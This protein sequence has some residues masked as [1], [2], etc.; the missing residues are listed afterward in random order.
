MVD[1]PENEARRLEALRR[2][3]ILDTPPEIA[4]D[5]ITELAAQICGCPIAL[6]GLIDERRDWLKAKY[7]PPNLPDESPRDSV[8]CATVINRSDLLHVPDLSQDPRFRDFP[9]VKGPPHQKFYCGM[10]LIT[11]DGYAVGTLCVTDIKPHELSV[12][13]QEAMRRLSRQVMTQLE[14][15][16][17]IVERNAMLGELDRMRQDA[18]E[19]RAKSDQLLRNVLPDPIARELQQTQRVQPRYYDSVSILFLD[20]VDFTSHAEELE[21]AVL[22]NQLDQLFTRFDEIAAQHRLEKLKTIGDAHMSAGGLPEPNRT[23]ALDAVL[24]GFAMLDFVER[25][26]RQREKLRM[27]P[28]QV[29]IGIHTGPVIAGVVGT[30][31][32]AYDVWGD[33]VNVAA[34]MEAAGAPGRINVSESTRHRIADVCATEPR[35]SIEVK[36][37]GPLA[38]HFVERLK[39]EYS[40]DAAGRQPGPAL[41]GRY[42]APPRNA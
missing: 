27:T 18:E 10:P 38:M 31:K 40:A 16:R 15:R 11:P 36:K 8:V 20:V 26:N 5:E 13:Q 19:A 12:D 4:Y 24:A 2:Y 9:M 30:Q 33:A 17:Q 37:K 21:P 23:H 29:R 32:F 22:V 34:R 39:P 41:A 3:Q 1:T 28:W 25:L 14:L 42:W 6:I 35:G 7:G